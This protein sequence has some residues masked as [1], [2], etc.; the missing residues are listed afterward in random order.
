MS[1][2]TEKYPCEMLVSIAYHSTGEWRGEP[3]GCVSDY[4][5]ELGYGI[6]ETLNEYSPYLGDLFYEGAELPKKSGVYKF[7]GFAE[8]CMIGGSDAPILF[9]GEFESK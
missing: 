8:V 2:C 6:K 4:K 9:K 1:E 3:Y 5:G 7:S